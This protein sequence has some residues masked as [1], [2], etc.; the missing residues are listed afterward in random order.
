[1]TFRRSCYELSQIPFFLQKWKKLKRYLVLKSSG[2]MIISIFFLNTSW[3][4]NGFLFIKKK[5]KNENIKLM[6]SFVWNVVA[7]PIT[8]SYF[9]ERDATNHILEIQK[10]HLKKKKK[11]KIRLSTKQTA[12]SQ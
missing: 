6:T 10:N 7:N 9:T 1:M 3:N 11:P 2:F 12:P 5:N 8:S 4:L